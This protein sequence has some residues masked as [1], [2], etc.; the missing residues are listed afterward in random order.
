[1]KICI[2]GDAGHINLISWVR[3]LAEV[4]SYEITILTFNEPPENLDGIRVHRMTPLLRGS[5][6]R[7]IM[8][9]P[10]IRK[11]VNKI[12]PDILI[13][14][15]INSYGL[16]AV[17][18]G[19][20]PVVVIAQGSDIF[21]GDQFNLKRMILSYVLRRVDLIHTW[22]THMRGKLLEYGA[23]EERIFVLPKGV[24]TDIFRPSASK[25]KEGPC[26]LISTRQLRKSYNHVCI[27]RALSLVSKSISHFQY[28]ICGDGE[29]KN[30]LERITYNLG[31]KNQ[32]QFLGR[33]NHQLLPS[34]LGSSDIYISMQPSD[35]VSAS[36]LEAMACGIFPIVTDIQANRYWI[37]HG[38]NGFLVTA[39]DHQS[40]AT[41]IVAALRNQKLRD[42]A[43]ERNLTLISE[44]GVMRKNA[45]KT[46][47]VYSK[48]ISES[49]RCS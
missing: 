45:E 22:E 16:L 12:K 28:L 35:G 33:I 31:I 40:L 15:R 4:S 20:H 46:I 47:A 8:A 29:Y 37:D 13:G 49:K 5:R 7:Y 24:D 2:V 36:L 10:K 18:T 19:W 44:R 38:V 23:R 42:E 17:S 21:G 27:L 34:L 26:I 3:G 39:N 48:V 43:K 14:Y 41:S 9:I 30:D 1:M 25:E 11:L 6:L 32:V